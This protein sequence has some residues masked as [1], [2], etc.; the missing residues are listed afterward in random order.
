MRI[1][2]VVNLQG[3]S[4]PLNVLHRFLRKIAVVHGISG[5]LQAKF[6]DQVIEGVGAISPTAERDYAIVLRP[7]LLVFPDYL[8]QG[9]FP[10]KFSRDIFLTVLAHTILIEQRAGKIAG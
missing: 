7:G 8:Q 10:Q 3:G 9:F 6:V 1:E 4:C 2:L 5:S